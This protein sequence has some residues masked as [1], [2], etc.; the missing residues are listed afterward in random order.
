ME[1]GEVQLK[2][3]RSNN[4]KSYNPHKLVDEFM[5]SEQALVKKL[6]NIVFGNEANIAYKRN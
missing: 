3:P 1:G 2:G 4:R 5:T 6:L